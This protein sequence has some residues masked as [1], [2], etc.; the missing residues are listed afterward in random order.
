MGRRS[1][2]IDFIHFYAWNVFVIFFLLLKRKVLFS[3]VRRKN[4]FYLFGVCRCVCVPMHKRKAP[5]GCVKTRQHT[6]HCMN[7]TFFCWKICFYAVFITLFGYHLQVSQPA[8]QRFDAR[9]SQKWRVWTNWNW[10]IYLSELNVC[11]TLMKWSAI[12]K[13][14]KRIQLIQSSFLFFHHLFFCVVVHFFFRSQ[15]KTFVVVV[16]VFE[17]IFIVD[18]ENFITT[19]ARRERERQRKNGKKKIPFQKMWTNEMTTITIITINNI[20]LLSVLPVYPVTTTP[21]T[22]ATAPTPV[23]RKNRASFIK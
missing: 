17:F 14:V 19:E 9:K 18:S 3:F 1:A 11:A 8:S 16:L 4:S 12:E 13:C 21:T 7:V 23:I 6:I 20:R 15:W 5:D 2:S 10:R 22:T